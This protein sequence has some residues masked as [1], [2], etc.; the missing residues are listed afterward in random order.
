MTSFI[1]RQAENEIE[2]RRLQ[3]MQ[4]AGSFCLIAPTPTFSH[5]NTERFM[6]E[7]SMTQT[8]YFAFHHLCELFFP[9]PMEGI[10][11][12]HANPIE[13]ILSKMMG[14]SASRRDKDFFVQGVMRLMDTAHY[15]FETCYTALPE[16]QKLEVLFFF[17]EE[18]I[19]L[20]WTV[21]LLEL[22]T[23]SLAA[24]IANVKNEEK[25]VNLC[26]QKVSLFDYSDKLPKM[27]RETSKKTVQQKY[28][29]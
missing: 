4:M 6:S 26:F 29:A 5:Q 28:L 17:C 24:F 20:R 13:F 12:S 7:F 9:T 15:H 25:S 18:K 27:F 21:K 2:Q 10:S 1:S 14:A 23:Q 11:I 8:Q 16:M 3:I 22:L 19:W